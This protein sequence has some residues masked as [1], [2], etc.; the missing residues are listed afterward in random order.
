MWRELFW[1]AREQTSLLANEILRLSNV[2]RWFDRWG[3]QLNAVYRARDTLRNSST[4]EANEKRLRKSKTDVFT[5]GLFRYIASFV[6]YRANCGIKLTNH[7]L[8]Y[9]SG[10]FSIRLPG[11][12]RSRHR[13]QPS[14]DWLPGLSRRAREFNRL[15]YRAYRGMVNIQYRVDHRASKRYNLIASN[16]LLSTRDAS[17]PRPQP[18]TYRRREYHRQNAVTAIGDAT[19]ATSNASPP[20]SLP[21]TPRTL[22]VRHRRHRFR[23]RNDRCWQCHDRY[24]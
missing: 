15:V 22:S 21:A 24:R 5:V 14:G 16:S 19:T 17:A 7:R 23:Q 9:R 13:S 12:P 6:E 2:M 3:N 4:W 8:D 11:Q 10:L 20:P 1:L 18:A